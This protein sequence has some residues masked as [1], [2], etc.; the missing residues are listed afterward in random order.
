M[1]KPVQRPHPPFVIGGG[2]PKILALAA[3]EA[4]IVGINANLRS[5]D[6]ELARC[7][8]VADARR[9]PTRSSRGCAR[10]R[11]TRFDDL[12]IQTLRRVRARHRRPRRRSREA[13]ARLVRRRPR[14]RARRAGDARRDRVDEIVELL[15]APPRALADVVRRGPR[16]SH[17]RAR[18][19]S[20]RAS[21]EPRRGVHGEAVPVRCAGVGR[22]LG[23]ARGATR[24][25]SSRTSATRRCSCPTTSATR[26]RAAARD[27]DGGRAH[28]DAARRRARVRQRLQAPGDPRQGDRD[29]R[30]A[31][32]T[33]ASSSASARAG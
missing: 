8:A 6:G 11:A 5:G 16:R 24:R 30:P 13:M 14:G 17:R 27:R 1:P 18:A 12:E 29:D 19:R 15:E 23:R 28:D 4:Q 7:R 20:S 9:R 21:R 32:A 26:A 22:R 25:A 31:V 33:A 3:R 10:P 2:G